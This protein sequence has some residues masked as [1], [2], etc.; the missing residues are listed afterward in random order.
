MLYF[1]NDYSEGAHEEVLKHLI[2]TNMEQLS[3][4]LKI[5]KNAID[6][7]NE[8]KQ[9]LREKGNEFFN[10]CPYSPVEKSHSNFL[11]LHRMM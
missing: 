9:V 6:T 7:A 8:L 11:L 3:L 10:D 5:G 1:T 4:Y 2:E